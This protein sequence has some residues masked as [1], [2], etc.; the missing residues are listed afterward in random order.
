MRMNDK[1]ILVARLTAYNYS[2]IYLIL[3]FTSEEDF[4]NVKSIKN[5]AKF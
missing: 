3:E 5:A 4:D 2:F 1:Y